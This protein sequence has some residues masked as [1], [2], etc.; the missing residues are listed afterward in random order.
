MA[1]AERTTLITAT[2]GC[3]DEATEI[4]IAPFFP[5]HDVRRVTSSGKLLHTV[6]SL[7]GFFSGGRPTWWL[8]VSLLF[9]AFIHRGERLG[10]VRE[11]S[12]PSNK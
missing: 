3:L 10:K 7:R 4:I 9:T 2:V 8:N 11:L 6:G 1:P 5:Q 12:R